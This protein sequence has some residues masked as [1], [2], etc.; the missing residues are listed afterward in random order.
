MVKDPLPHPGSATDWN[1]LTDLYEAGVE[2]VLVVLLY[3]SD[4]RVLEGLVEVGQEHKH[5]HLL[6][7]RVTGP[8][9]DRLQRPLQVG[10]LRP[11]TVNRRDPDRQKHCKQED[12][13]LCADLHQQISS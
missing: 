5:D 10:E 1:A 8:V 3:V 13:G 12:R 11:L 2:V 9:H 7:L 6:L 4:D